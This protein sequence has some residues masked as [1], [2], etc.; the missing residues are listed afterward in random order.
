MSKLKLLLEA[1]ADPN[2]SDGDGE[3]PEQCLLR[4]LKYPTNKHKEAEVDEAIGMMRRYTLT[5][6]AE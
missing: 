5:R 1:G 6:E 2:L 3:T 4:R